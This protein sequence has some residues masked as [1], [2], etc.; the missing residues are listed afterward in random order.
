MFIIAQF[1]LADFRPLIKGGKGQLSVPD[2]AS[3]NLDSGFI[4]GFGQISARNGSSLGLGGERSFADMNNAIRFGPVGFRQS[5]WNKSLPLALW[6]RRLYFDGEMAGRFEVGF[7][8]PQGDMLDTFRNQPVDPPLIAQAILSNYVEVHSVDG[9]KRRV[10]F[11]ACSEP[12]GLAYLASTTRNDALSEFP[13]AETYGAEVFV[14][15]PTLHIRIPLG[16]EIKT[17]NDRRCLNADDEP[18]FFITSARDSD[19]RNNVLVQASAHGVRDESAGERVTRV[20][21]AHL[22]ALLFAHAQFVKAG[23]EISGLNGRD[24]LR[25]AISKMIERFGRFSQ[26]EDN[27]TDKGFAEGMRLFARAYAG[28]IDDLVAKLHDLSA[29]WNKP[30]TVESFKRYAKALHDLILTTAVKT[31]VAKALEP[32]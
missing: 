13:I 11:A 2:W 28:R 32:K 7:M 18:E 29:E 25:A 10:A 12:L 21:F 27:E 22:N 20:L 1:P 24:V 15:K 8:V 26:I 9:S 19:T 4:R 16:L 3:D 31:M 17:S 14:G 23:R 6:F 30:T 5:G